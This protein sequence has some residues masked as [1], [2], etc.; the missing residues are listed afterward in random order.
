M[1]VCRYAC[2]YVCFS[3]SIYLYTYIRA[4]LY[5]YA[6]TYKYTNEVILKKKYNIFTIQ[7]VVIEHY[8]A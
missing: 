6:K 2:I 3:I 1:H 4:Y 8:E 7:N 5:M